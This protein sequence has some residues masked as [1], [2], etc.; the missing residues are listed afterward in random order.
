MRVRFSK[1]QSHII[2]SFLFPMSNSS[3]RVSYG[4]CS[5]RLALSFSPRCMDLIGRPMN[6]LSCPPPPRATGNPVFCW[7][8]I[9]LANGEETDKEVAPKLNVQGKKQSPV[10]VE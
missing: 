5:P 1:K 2:D 7:S 3:L 8:L 6:Y 10:S 9:P 4:S